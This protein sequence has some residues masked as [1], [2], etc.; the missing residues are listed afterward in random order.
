VTSGKKDVDKPIKLAGHLVR[1]VIWMDELRK[2]VAVL[3]LSAILLAFAAPALAQMRGTP[4]ASPA[5]MPVERSNKDMMATLMD[6]KDTSMAA[7]I[8]KKGGLEGMMKPEGKYTLFV[9]SNTALNATSPGMLNE[10]MDKLKDRQFA[11][12]F[13]KGHMVNGM[14]MPSEMT[15]GKTLAMMNGKTMTVRM[16]DGRMMVDDATI[17][18]AI[19]TNNGV[20]YVMDKI[21][22][23]IMTMLEEMGMSPMSAMPTSR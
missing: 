2:I 18:K 22:S 20:I 19:K 3:T 13:V 4:M 21:P 8:M 23:S 15:D 1:S 9:A 6:T 7:S 16:M 11:I 10:M 12:Y 17:T 5:M 14:V